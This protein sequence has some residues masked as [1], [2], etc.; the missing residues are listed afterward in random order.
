MPIS[1]I[2]GGAGFIGSHLC[3]RLLREGH[4]VICIDN[5]ITGRYENL[6]DVINNEKFEFIERD[7]CE[8][9]ELSLKPDYILHLASPASPK[10]FEELSIHILKTGSIGTYNMLEIAKNCS[11]SFLLASSSEVYGDAE[12]HPQCESYWGRVNPVG[13]RSPYD[14]AKRFSESFTM[15]YKRKFN[16]KTHIARIFNTYGPRMRMDDGRVI[17]NFIKQAFSGKHLTI[18]GDG[19][20]TRSFCYVSDMVEGLFRLVTSNFCE[21]V[22]L[23]NPE[24]ISI[25]ELAEIICELVGVKPQFEYRPLPE[26][27]PLKRKPDIERAGRELDWEPEVTLKDGLG[28]TVRYF[29]RILNN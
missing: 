12:V 18:Y 13:P 6:G 17:P 26:D 10:D 29:K 5:L 27:D 16:I 14:E 2:T 28:E 23:G 4:S 8:D 22:N 21:P 3:E 15:A 20:Q 1:I 19:E 7:I 24:E 25:I 11:S 9:I